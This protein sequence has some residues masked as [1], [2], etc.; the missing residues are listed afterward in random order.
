MLIWT[1]FAVLG[2]ALLSIGCCER[3][4]ALTTIPAHA[5]LFAGIDQLSMALSTQSNGMDS[6]G[7]RPTIQGGA[8]PRVDG[9]NYSG[10]PKS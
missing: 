10:E 9:P 5:E 4:F 1:G 3:W 2:A 6:P 8:L 7:M